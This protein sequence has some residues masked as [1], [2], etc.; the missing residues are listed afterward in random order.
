M[1]WKN[2]LIKS[3][4]GLVVVIILCVPLKLFIVG[5]PIDHAQVYCTALVNG[6]ELKLR[7]ESVESSAAL[8]GWKLERDGDTL[9]IRARK[10]L[11]SPLFKE[12][13][14]ETVIDLKAIE[15]VVFGGQVIWPDVDER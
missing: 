6:Q 12:G 15:K 2:M 13:S 10:V 5:E 8:R 9:Y 7:I 4:V 3:I 1:N 11:V 14:Y